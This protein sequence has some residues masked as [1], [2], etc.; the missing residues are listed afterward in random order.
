MK[1][2]AGGGPVLT[3]V[4]VLAKAD[5]EICFLAAELP[6]VRVTAPDEDP[7]S[8]FLANNFCL[9]FVMETTVF[10]ESDNSVEKSRLVSGMKEEDL[11]LDRI[12]DWAFGHLY[13]A[14][15]QI[16]TS[17]LRLCDDVWNTIPERQTEMVAL[18]VLSHP[19]DEALCQTEVAIKR[20]RRIMAVHM[21]QVSV[22]MAELDFVSHS[23][24]LGRFYDVLEDKWESQNITPPKKKARNKREEKDSYS[25]DEDKLKPAA[26][27]HPNQE[28]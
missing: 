17:V 15:H 10:L 18:N 28:Q 9:G 24:A 1:F 23:M 7:R 21:A 16:V 27:W 8:T 3:L 11:I 25:N 2:W 19:F 5:S 4:T 6:P 13:Q 22:V 20:A 26:L 12:E 14:S